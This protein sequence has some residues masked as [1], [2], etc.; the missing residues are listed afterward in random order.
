[1]RVQSIHVKN[2]RCIRDAELSLDSLTA[3]VGRNGSGKSAFLSALELFYK[4][5]MPLTEDDFYCRNVGEP[6]EIT[7]TYGSLRP[8]EQKEFAKYVRDDELPIVGL[9]RFGVGKN[10]GTY[11]GTSLQHPAFTEVRNKPRKSEQIEAFNTLCDDGSF[12]RTH[13]SEVSG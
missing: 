11:H 10:P 8:A 5:E 2:Y 9:F 1:M 12:P 3:L 7:V 13:E 6:I 4:P